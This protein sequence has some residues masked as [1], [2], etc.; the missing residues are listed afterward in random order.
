M[1]FA[2]ED[3]CSLCCSFRF[4]STRE[5]VWCSMWRYVM[6]SFVTY[7]Q[8]QPSRAT[9]PTLHSFF[10][11]H[12]YRSESKVLPIEPYLIPAHAFPILND[13]SSP[14][15]HSPVPSQCILLRK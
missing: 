8:F 2:S 1:C 6:S 7:R 12:N 11:S 5:I 9:A 13:I 14:A 4:A 3:S 15:A 10:P